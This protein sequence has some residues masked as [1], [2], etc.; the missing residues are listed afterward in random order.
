MASLIFGPASSDTEIAEARKIRDYIYQQRLGLVPTEWDKEDQRDVYGTVMIMRD[1]GQAVATVRLTPITS[2]YAEM[3]DL[4]IVPDQIMNADDVMEVSRLAAIPRDN[5][6]SRP[7]S[8]LLLPAAARWCLDHTDAKR[9]IAYCRTSVLKLMVA[10]GSEPVGQ[11][12]NIRERT[13]E[14]YHVIKGDIAL[15][16][17][18]FNAEEVEFTEDVSFTLIARQPNTTVQEKQRAGS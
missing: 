8:G 18:L 6:R 14:T 15:T 17:A 5:N 3:H 11:P 13:E 12:F 4:G 7:Y 2:S 9:F 10:M 16:A 1:C